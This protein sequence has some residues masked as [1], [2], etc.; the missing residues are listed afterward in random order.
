MADILPF[1]PLTLTEGQRKIINKLKEM[2]EE[3]ILARLPYLKL[4]TL[5]IIEQEMS[6]TCDCPVLYAA[7]DCGVVHFMPCQCGDCRAA[8]KK[9][10]HDGKPWHASNYPVTCP[11]CGSAPDQEPC[12]H[13]KHCYLSPLVLANLRGLIFEEP[14]PPPMRSAAMTQ[15]DRAVMLALRAEAGTGLWNPA[16]LIYESTASP[17]NEEIDNDA[18]TRAG[19]KENGCPSD[20]PEPPANGQRIFSPLVRRRKKAG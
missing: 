14:P 10:I 11:D 13:F 8:K 1:K 3:N 18:W 6:P 19:W 5:E 9:A 2:S 20:V 15:E 7:C 12:E 16:D 4:D 17:I